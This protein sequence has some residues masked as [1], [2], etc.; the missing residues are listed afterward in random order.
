M[1]PKNFPARKLARQILA[2]GDKLKDYGKDLNDARN[3]RTK[4]NRSGGHS[5]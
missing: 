2:R 5:K 1:K 4:K 3:I